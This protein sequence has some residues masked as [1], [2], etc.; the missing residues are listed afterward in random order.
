MTVNSIFRFISLAIRLEQL[1][2]YL[3]ERELAKQE[4]KL[5]ELED[6]QATLQEQVKQPKNNAI[7][8]ADPLD[9]ENCG[10]SSIQRFQGEDNDYDSRKRQQQQQVRFFYYFYS[11]LLVKGFEHNPN[12]L[13]LILLFIS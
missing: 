13:T 10:P 3:E 1:C 11:I 4:V 8:M 6:V 12:H 7:F 5:K 9:L 2:N